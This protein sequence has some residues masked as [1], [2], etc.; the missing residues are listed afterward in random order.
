MKRYE[1]GEII[2][3]DRMEDEVWYPDYQDLMHISMYREDCD[4]IARMFWKDNPDCKLTQEQV[5]RWACVH[6]AIS[7]R[8]PEELKEEERKARRDYESKNGSDGDEG[9]SDPA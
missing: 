3:K 2:T 4:E 7:A 8:L 1:N 5:L 6:A 9:V